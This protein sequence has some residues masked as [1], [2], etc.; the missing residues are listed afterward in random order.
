MSSTRSKM[1]Q[2]S[3][4]LCLF[5]LIFSSVESQRP[6]LPFVNDL[7]DRCKALSKSWNDLRMLFDELRSNWRANIN[8][9]LP[10]GLANLPHRG[11][12]VHALVQL[13][14]FCEK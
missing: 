13:K 12:S 2:F 1:H 3:I 8:P 14:N 11:K 9:N 4:I 10:S 5:C 6:L 7:Y